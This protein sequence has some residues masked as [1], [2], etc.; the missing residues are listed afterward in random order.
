[1]QSIT[2]PSIGED[3]LVAS[4]FIRPFSTINNAD[5]PTVGGKNASLGEMYAHLTPAGIL[6]PNG[7]AVTAEAYR[8]VIERNSLL[9]LLHEALDGLDWAKPED[10]TKRTHR[11]H[12]AVAHAEIPDDLREEILKAY[13]D[14]RVHYGD[15]MTVAVRSSA[16]AEDLPNASFAGQ[17]E[18]FVNVAG[19]E[20]VIEAYRQAI[21][22]LFLERA[23]HYRIDGGFD[24][25]RIAL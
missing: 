1:M 25:F 9:A 18:S 17:H 3:R 24:H 6:V 5:V 12:R 8:Y 10:F 22:S 20:M 14:L 7:F 16:T 2:E 23:I 19:D 21:A 13:H 15:S 11:A 4:R